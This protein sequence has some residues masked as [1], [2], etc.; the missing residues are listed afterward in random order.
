MAVKRQG[1]EGETVF[2]IWRKSRE[3]V[4]HLNAFSGL[5]CLLYNRK[6]N[7]CC[8]GYI[9]K[10][11]FWLPLRIKPYG[12]V[13]EWFCNKWGLCVGGKCNLW[14]YGFSQG[15]PVT[16]NFNGNN[17]QLI[18]NQDQFPRVPGA[19]I[20][21]LRK[22]PLQGSLPTTVSLWHVNH[23]LNFVS[24]FIFSVHTVMRR[25]WLWSSCYHWWVWFA[26]WDFNHGFSQESTTCS[27]RWWL[28]MFSIAANI[29]KNGYEI[30]LFCF[31]RGDEKHLSW[32]LQEKK[33]S[34]HVISCVN[35]W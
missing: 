13:V 26:C 35:L 1:F 2:F 6:L 3:V 28:L 31:Q 22:P 4:R 8:R 14:L 27:K 25:L 18:P 5:K 12:S 21:S 30:T 15:T 16:F 9:L 10:I 24:Q 7:F 17:N 23:L 33:I 29:K 20:L 32:M 19:V 11:F 34:Q